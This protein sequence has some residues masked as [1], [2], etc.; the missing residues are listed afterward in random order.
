VEK[1]NAEMEIQLFS[2]MDEYEIN[3]VCAMLTE[4]N[5]PFIR[6]DYG[7]G[8][9]MNLYMGHSIQEK[10]IFI[11][12]NDYDKATEIISIFQ[13]ANED[14]LDESCEQIE[15]EDPQKKYQLI[16][17]MLGFLILGVPIIIVIMLIIMS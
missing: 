15:E 1:D 16:K 3:Q 14:V 9:Y 13:N 7:T 4:N 2:S 11:S 10:A 8:S 17:R 5:I 6:R 12:Q